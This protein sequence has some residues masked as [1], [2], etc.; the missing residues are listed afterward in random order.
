MN[1][2]NY[3]EY[4]EYKC[5]KCKDCYPARYAT[6]SDRTSCRNHYYIIYKNQ[7]IC[8]D[9][10]IVKGSRNH[11]CYHVSTRQWCCFQ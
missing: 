1:S 7:E 11:N 8:R 6:I 3:H 10:K 4:S 2:I 9:C 5:D